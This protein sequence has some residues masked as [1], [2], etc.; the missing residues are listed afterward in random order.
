MYDV[1]GDTTYSKYPRSEADLGVRI[2]NTVF[3]ARISLIALTRIC[4]AMEIVSST[5]FKYGQKTHKINSNT[6][7]ENTW[8]PT[9]GKFEQWLWL[10]S[11]ATG[12]RVMRGP[13]KNNC[14]PYNS[15]SL[16]QI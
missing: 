8:T 6:V 16:K 12:C 13:F 7:S 4:R 10:P 5:S 9:H 3:S 1:L 15:V 2:H 14:P 11:R